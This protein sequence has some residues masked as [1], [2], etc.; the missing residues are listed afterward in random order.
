M[1]LT[2]MLLSGL[3]TLFLL[4]AASQTAIAPVRALLSAALGGLYA[5]ACMIPTLSFLGGSLWRLVSLL[6]IGSIS[7]GIRK[8]GIRQSLLFVILQLTVTGLLSAANSPLAAVFLLVGF[9]LF[10]VLKKRKNTISVAIEYQDKKMT[11]LAWKDTGN[12]LKD[13]L[14][15]QPVLIIDATAAEELTGLTK[16]QLND[17]VSTMTQSGMPGLR[18]IPY[19][20][21]DRPGGMLLG[22][23][24][25]NVRIGGRKKSAVVAFAPTNFGKEGNIRAL[26]GGYV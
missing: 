5:G 18:L 3:V 12:T 6:V 14:T 4:M 21:I 11:L 16:K 10:V 7:F 8:E 15:A 22:L 19:H 26:T 20:T 1:I 9:G 13:P 24:I 25:E 2:V 23:Y 17:P